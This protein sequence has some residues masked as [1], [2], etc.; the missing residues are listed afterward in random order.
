VS[1]LLTATTKVSKSSTDMTDDSQETKG[2]NNKQQQQLTQLVLAFVPQ[3]DSENVNFLFKV[4]KPQLQVNYCWSAAT[5]ICLG[6][7][8]KYSKEIF[9]SAAAYLLLPS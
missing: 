2:E 9:Q 4:L 1:K 8:S 6:F 7:I 3:L 5:D